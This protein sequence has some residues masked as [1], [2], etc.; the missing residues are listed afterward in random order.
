MSHNK[1]VKQELRKYAVYQLMSY[2]NE[3][4]SGKYVSHEQ[5]HKL[6]KGIENICLAAFGEN[7]A[8]QIKK[9]APRILRSTLETII[10][11]EL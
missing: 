10:K 8:Q 2:V 11:Q 3:Q 4:T 6:G 7:Y 9:E 1:D 5:M